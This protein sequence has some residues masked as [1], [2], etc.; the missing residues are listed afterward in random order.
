MPI[1]IQE[2][3]ITPNKWDQK[4]K[5]FCHIII[6]TL[7]AQNK[8]RILKAAREKGQVTYQ[9]RP[10]RIASGFSTETIKTRK[11]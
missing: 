4:T 7:N 9:G 8:E 10:I 6:K 2:A 11:A 5:S 3:Y 1:K